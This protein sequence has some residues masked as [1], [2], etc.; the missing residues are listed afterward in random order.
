M[1]LIENNYADIGQYFSKM[2]NSVDDALT[3]ILN[4]CQDMTCSKGNVTPYPFRIKTIKI[5]ETV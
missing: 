1:I 3:N 2:T 5:D 4:G